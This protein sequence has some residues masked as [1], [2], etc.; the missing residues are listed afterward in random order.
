MID[1]LTVLKWWQEC[2]IRSS[3]Q[4]AV[5]SDA[6]IAMSHQQQYLD[7]GNPHGVPWYVVAALHMRESDFNFHTYLGNG[8][9]L[10]NHAGVGVKSVHVPRGR[11]PFKDWAAGADDA[12]T[13]NGWSQIQAPSTHWDIVTAL[14]KMED[15][16]GHGYR[17]KALPSPYVWALTSVQ[18]PGKYVADGV[19]DSS[20][21][22]HQVGC[23]ALLLALKTEHGVDLNEA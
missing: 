15:Y 7:A 16:N 1:R 12:L 17:S 14:R 22:D 19:W 4:A 2:K 9:P 13:L 20:Y 3:S 6:K 21:M 5:D 10:F 8:D 11:G 23:A 18:V